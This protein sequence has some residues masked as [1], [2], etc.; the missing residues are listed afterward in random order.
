[1]RTTMHLDKTVV[2]R[3]SEL[4]GIRER[5]ALVH[6]SL[7]TLIAHESARRL[8]ALGGSEKH[9]GQIPRRRGAGGARGTR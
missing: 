8:A 3:A 4:T 7:R 2:E 1:M 5:T 9:L 6:L